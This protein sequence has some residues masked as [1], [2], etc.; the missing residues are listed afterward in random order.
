MYERVKIHSKDVV[1]YVLAGGYNWTTRYLLTYDM[2][3]DVREISD[4]SLFLLLLHT[5]KSTVRRQFGRF[6]TNF[7]DPT[8]H[9]E[10]GE[11]KNGLKIT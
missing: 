4:R 3:G 6:V 11:T 2:V 9:R 7:A 10:W 8:Y 5:L 1:M